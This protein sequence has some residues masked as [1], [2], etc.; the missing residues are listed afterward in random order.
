MSPNPSSQPELIF[1]LV[2]PI[3][4][5]MNSVQIA[6]EASLRSVGYTPHVI[7]LTKVVPAALPHLTSPVTYDEKIQFVNELCEK[8][9]KRTSSLG[10]LFLKSAIS[11]RKLTKV[12]KFQTRQIFPSLAQPT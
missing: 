6:L 1:G 5:D 3:G 10:L 4:T 12:T 9:K 7:H 8:T 2:G 11:V